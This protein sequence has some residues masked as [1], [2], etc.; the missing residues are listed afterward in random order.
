M[1]RA[2]LAAAFA[3]NGEDDR[4]AAELAQA[5]GLS[6]DA[7]TGAA[8]LKAD[9]YFGVPSVRALYEATYSAGLCGAGVPEE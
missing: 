2:E 1:F 8:R 4:D 5:R 9:K 6:C 7:V 3:L